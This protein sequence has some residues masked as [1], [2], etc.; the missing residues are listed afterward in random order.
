MAWITKK[1]G[2]MQIERR[3]EPYLTEAIKEDFRTRMFPR[4]PDKQACTIPLL[5]AI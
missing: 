5:H 1:S 3:D 4:Y 2:T